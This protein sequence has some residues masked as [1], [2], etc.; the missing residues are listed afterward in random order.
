MS[1]SSF[2][3][4]AAPLVPIALGMSAF[5]LLRRLRIG[6]KKFRIRTE[7]RKETTDSSRAKDSSMREM[8]DTLQKYFVCRLPV[9]SSELREYNG[10]CNAH[11]EKFFGN[12]RDM[13]HAI[14]LREAYDSLMI[15]GYA[16][17]ALSSMSCGRGICDL[18]FDK[19]GL[20]DI[21]DRQLALRFKNNYK[22]R[23]TIFARSNE[24][25]LRVLFSN[26]KESAIIMAYLAD[27]KIDI[28]DSHDKHDN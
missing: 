10:I 28:F 11:G 18:A 9:R 5:L 4:F 27:Y 20:V 3:S 26:R 1:F 25:L 23:I 8:V 15:G 16:G 12:F 14:F 2:F 24:E 6:G 13:R 19:L 22:S 17:D 21:R 7:P